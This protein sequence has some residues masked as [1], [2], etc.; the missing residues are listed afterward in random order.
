[1]Y[2]AIDEFF[3]KKKEK[4]LKEKKSKKDVEE[5]FS[6]ENWLPK[7]AKKAKQLSFSSHPSKFSHPHA[8]NITPIIAK[9]E[10][11]ND[12]Y[13]RSGNVE[14]E[15]DAEGHAAAHRVYQFLNLKMEDGK[16]LLEH[17]EGETGV[18]KKLFAIKKASYEE[19]R[20]GFLKIKKDQEKM[21]TSHLIKQ[22]FFPV[23]N[24]EYHQLSVLMP[25]GIMYSMHKK[26]EE[27]QFGEETKKARNCRK[28]NEYHETGYKEIFGL[29]KIFYGGEQPQNISILNNKARHFYLLSS[30]PPRQEKRTL[31]LPKK[32]FFKECIWP[33]KY[34]EKFL[35]LHRL[36]SDYRNNR[37][38]RE[39]IKNCI[40]DI[41]DHIFKTI[42]EIRNLETGW[43]KREY[44]SGLPSYQK[45]ILDN[46]YKEE[47]KQHPEERDS[48]LKEISR[49]IVR[50]YEEILREEAIEMYDPEIRSIYDDLSND[51]EILL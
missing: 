29:A 3:S 33:K 24:G 25:S 40:W 13:L 5:K 50:S 19:L 20:D 18:A 31:R 44:Y 4:E 15:L 23:E 38:I 28:N 30:V 10:K 26:I 37:D 21:Q 27:M 48:F 32:D 11:K 43:T 1:M 8:K 12:G 47:R 22:V 39:K 51:K 41:F 6:L 42:L 46:A 14:C 36:Y 7:A 2:P 49:W 17:I 9:T 45:Y 16:T 34:K 35:L